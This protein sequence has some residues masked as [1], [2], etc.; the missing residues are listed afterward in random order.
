MAIKL[1]LRPELR[2]LATF[3]PTNEASQTHAI[4]DADIAIDAKGGS[5]ADFLQHA[6]ENRLIDRFDGLGE[7]ALLPG[8]IEGGRAG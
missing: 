6:Y 2:V 7:F 5:D 1:R 4:A 3:L 8:A